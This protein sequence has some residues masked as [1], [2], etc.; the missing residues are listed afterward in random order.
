[1]IFASQIAQRPPYAVKGNACAARKSLPD[2]MGSGCA[3]ENYEVQS[4]KIRKKVDCPMRAIRQ[5]GPKI[6]AFDGKLEEERVRNGVSL[7][8]R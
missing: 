4:G 7:S 6:R 1:L 2:N 3:V 5:S 8:D